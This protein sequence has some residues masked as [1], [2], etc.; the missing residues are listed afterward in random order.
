MKQMI[1]E[2]TK[3]IRCQCKCYVLRQLKNTK[4]GTNDVEHTLMRI[5]DHCSNNFK[6]QIRM[7]MMRHKIAGAY[8]LL[9][10][11]Q[12]DCNKAWRDYKRITPKHLQQQFERLFKAESRRSRDCIRRKAEEKVEWLRAKWKPRR[13]ET[14]TEIRGIRM[15]DSDL[16][17]TTFDTNPRVYG[18]IEIG[19]SEEKVLRLPPKFGLIEKVDPTDCL[20]KVERCLNQIRWRRHIETDDRKYLFDNVR[21]EI[22]INNLRPTD[23]HYNTKV[24]MPGPVEFEEEM[25]FQNFKREVNEAAIRIAKKTKK[26]SN[27]DIE[28]IEG[29]KS[30]KQKTKNEE[31]ICFN[32]DKSGRWSVDS[33]ENYLL[34]CNKHFEKGVREITSDEH[35][36]ME[37]HINC[38]MLAL[39]RMMGLNEGKSGDRIRNASTTTGCVIAPFYALR[40]DHKPVEVGREAEGPKTRGVCGARDC[41]TM[42]LSHLLS[43][44]LKELIPQHDTHCDSTE[45]LLASIEM[46]NNEGNVKAGWKCGSLDIVA[47]YPSLDIPRCAE[48]VT[49]M[50]YRSEIKIKNIKWKEVMLYIRFMWTDEQIEDKGLLEYIPKRRTPRGR[51]P[52]FLASG[53]ALNEEQRFKPWVWG[54]KEPDGDDEKRM[55]SIAIGIMVTQTITNHAYQHNNQIYKQEEGGAIGL[56]LVGVIAN[57]YMCWWDQ[58]LLRRVEAENIRIEVYKRYVDDCNIIANDCREDTT[59][60]M[61]ITRISQIA[62]TIDPA[63][64]ST[65]D[66]GSNYED[67]RLPMLDLKLWIGQRNDGTWKI[68][69][70]HYMKDVSSRY[71]IHA[72][73]SHPISMKINVLVNE[74]LR[75]LRNTNSSLGWDEA[76]RHLQYFVRRMQFSG[77]DISM[78][79][80]IITKILKKHDETMTKFN[81]TGKMYRS[82]K[83]QY[84]ERRKIKDAKKTGWYDRKKYDGV[85]FV[86]V[87]EDN[88]LKREV[89]RLCKKNK[90]NVK[91]VEKMRGTVKS[92]LQRSNP[93]RKRRCGR[94]DCVVCDISDGVDC[95]TRGCV[96]EIRCND[97]SRKYIGQTGRSL[98]E[99]IKEHFSDYRQ[100]KE[101]SVLFE[102]SEM[103]HD[104]QPFEI[105]VSILSRCFGEPTT[106]LISEA[107]KINELSDDA[108]LNS[109]SE[110]TYV[111]L[112][113]P[114]R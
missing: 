21:R 26:Y 87:T 100:K 48:V 29:L 51:P 66:V 1:K 65:Y 91:V 103:Y 109:R 55:V 68:L 33:K 4:T 14:P 108:T 6:M 42:R 38:Q 89:Q 15:E 72:R 39:L 57:I 98:Y 22:D 62:D 63:I 58:Q 84:D 59:D 8:E 23:L 34:A 9:R 81:E 110:W 44:V 30:L 49:E 111:R 35:D 102:H 46:C 101:K 73:S 24:M 90:M 94:K 78:R 7:K 12:A 86:D 113:N 105:R 88:E 45:D 18:N 40:K 77:Y 3:K 76:K 28:E 80:T 106:R 11:K 10:Q 56:E 27:L 54:P 85:L 96:Y 19:P 17:S 74:G 61:V 69:H 70:S 5:A 20:I 79:G 53:S 99:R 60:E 47:L 31:V 71:V 97:C 13:P 104:K 83:E 112:H 25:R 2:N 95:R 43:Q 16:N 36:A 82:R 92:E 107:V 32:T 41:L 52:T 37:K 75:I 67:G 50:M 64:K 93:F 114:W